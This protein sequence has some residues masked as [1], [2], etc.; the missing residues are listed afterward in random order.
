MAQPL[1]IRNPA[2]ERMRAG[3]VALG[4]SVRL[5]R[6]PE[7]VRIAKATGHDFMFIDGQHATFGV[8]T[9]VTLAA[10]ALP[11]G[12]APLY[13]VRSLADPDTAMLLDNGV[14]GIIF[15]DINTAEEARRAVE[16]CKFAPVGRRSVGAVFPQ[17]EGQTPPLAEALPAINRATAVVIMVETAKGLENIEAIAKVPG[18][19]VVHIGTNDL[20]V[21]LGKP[22]QLDDPAVDRALD[23]CVAAC[24]AAGVF[25]GCGGIRDIKRQAALARRGLQFFSTQS[26]TALLTAA[27]KAW[28]DGVRGG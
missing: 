25:A 23:R 21:D 16:I 20:M 19:D 14:S 18:V 22:G 15:P 28:V 1:E 5:S 10:S 27:G 11:L 3:G 7:I 13:R 8:E 2:L 4:M 9:V 24:K 6:S 12:V 26:D 17:F